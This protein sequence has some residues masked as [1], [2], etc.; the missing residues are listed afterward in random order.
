MRQI[1]HLDCATVVDEWVNR[2]A[3]LPQEI[4]FMQEEIGEKDKELSECVRIIERSDNS[5]QKWIRLNGSHVQNPREEILRREVYRNYD[6]IEVLQ[7]QKI[8]LIENTQKLVDKHTRWLDTQIMG[9]EDRNELQHDPE[10]PSMLRPP[11]QDRPARVESSSAAMPLSQIA[12]SATVA[13]ARHPNQYPAR[14]HHAQGQAHQLAGTSASSA[15]ATPA[16]SLVLNRQVRESSL[17]AT[18]SKRQRL[19]GGL[20]TLPAT[21][22][23]LARHSS[24][25]PN[26]PRAGTP[27]VGVR[28]GSAG[29]KAPKTMT[30]NKKVVPTSSRP[31]AVLRKGK[32][33]KSNLSRIKRTGKNSLSANDSDLSEAESGTPEEDDEAVTP[34]AARDGDGDEDMAEVDEEEGG[35]DKKYCTCHSVSYGNMVA[36]DNNGCP[37]EWFHWNCVGLKSEPVGLWI[38][39]VCTRSMKKPGQ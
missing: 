26:T 16:A 11:T 28:A 37:F 25:T 30:G 14:T 4:S 13:P 34:L 24:L 7:A 35:D 23:N 36:C 33:G 6:R 31:S 5:I 18:S 38:C 22:S 32:P 9:L 8:K 21:S 3:N 39:P 17:G 10:L 1:E 2:T 29:P 20:G 15:P 19:T 27:G 12:N